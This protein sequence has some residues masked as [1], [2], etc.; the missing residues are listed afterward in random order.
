MQVRTCIDGQIMCLT[1]SCPHLQNQMAQADEAKPLK[2]FLPRFPQ[3]HP[4]LEQA[5]RL[6]TTFVF[7]KQKPY[8]APPPSP[9]M[10]SRKRTSPEEAEDQAVV[11]SPAI[12][13]R[14]VV[15]PEART[16][17]GRSKRAVDEEEDATR[18]PSIE[19]VLR[20]NRR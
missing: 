16:Q 18:M 12:K 9:P 14:T 15:V 1:T 4:S 13:K 6:F 19:Q 5:S 10:A 8:P 17:E 20:S 11:A 3:S 2:H 7:Q